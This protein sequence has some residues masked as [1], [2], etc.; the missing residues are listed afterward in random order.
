MINL[1]NIKIS[2]LRLGASQVKA[3]YFGSEQVWGGEEHGTID[4]WL[5]FTAEQDGSTLRLDKVG[6]PAEIY[7]ETSNDEGVTWK[8]YTWAE[9]TGAEYT[10]LNVGDK[11]YFRAKTENQTIGSSNSDY[12]KFVMTGK[13]AASGNIQALLKADGS[14]T[15]APTYCYFDIFNNCTALTYAPALP[16]TTLAGSCYN[17]MFSGCTSLTQAP[18]LPAT[19]LVAA[20]YS[21]MFKGCTALT[22]APALPVTT[23]ANNCYAGMFN[24]CSSLTQAPVLPATTLAIG[25]YANMFYRCGSLTSAPALP[26]TTLTEGCYKYMFRYCTSLTTAPELPATT[27]ADY[28]YQNMFRDCTS[29]TSVPELP[30]STLAQYCYSNMFDKC[31]SLTSAQAILPATT[32]APYCYQSL[33]SGCSSLTSA[34]AI[35]PATTLADNCYYYMFANCSSLTTAPKLPTTTLANNCYASMFQGCSNLA[36]I[37]VSFTAWEPTNATTRWVTG[38]AASGT[39][40]C[41][42]QLPDTRGTSNIPAGWTKVGDWLCF[43]AQEAGSTVKL[44]KVKSAPDVNLQTSTNGSSWTPY[45]V[46][47]VITLANVNDKVYFKAVGSNSVMG[48]SQSNYNK[49]VMTG[50][51]A[52]SGNVNSLLEEDKETASTM[53]LEGKNYCYNGMF[54][55]CSSLTQAPELPATTLAGS[56]YNGMFNGCSSLTQAP[57]L[58]ATT[59]AERC[60]NGM[61]RNCARLTQAPVLPATTLANN[62]YDSMFNGCKALTQAPTLPATTLYGYCYSSM[63]QDCSSLT[64]APELPA[65]TLARNC[66]SYMFRRCTSLSSLKVAFTAWEGQTANWVADVAATG[67]FTCPA[68]LPDTRGVN[69]IP[70]GWT[71]VDAA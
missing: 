7:L 43:T 52:A 37:N 58:P 29:L 18:E 31:T 53:S 54:N 6:S 3:V 23:L 65:T 4:D 16:A 12:Y 39:F 47:D 50:K 32:L 2:D 15:D 24:G 1:G 10:N 61:F 41:P 34:P 28:C 35:L 48:S 13:I 62:C 64:S 19:T 20:C 59:L 27:L 60:Y 42:A 49:F 45:A 9:N 5:C 44:T 38:V 56:C 66:Y 30:A 25:C 68:E 69:N 40:T 51:I 57:A 11:V 17:S 55:G 33:F 22:S 26:A 8:D 46:E 70:A 71:K 36:S 67:T 21:N 63:F 14:R